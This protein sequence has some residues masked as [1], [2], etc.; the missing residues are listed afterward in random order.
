M[1]CVNTFTELWLEKEQ[2]AMSRKQSV[3]VIGCT[4]VHS[5]LG[6]AFT[7]KRHLGTPNMYQ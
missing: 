6:L 1:R 4:S 7:V 5:S 2:P 3:M